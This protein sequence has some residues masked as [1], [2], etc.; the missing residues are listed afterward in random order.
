MGWR[1]VIA[2]VAMA[3]MFLTMC[4]APMAS[5]Q[6]H[7]ELSASPTAGIVVNSSRTGDQVTPSVFSIGDDKV[8]VVWTEQG[9]GLSRIFFS[10]ST[11]DGKTFSERKRVDDIG[12]TVKCLANDP[13][14][15]ANDNGTTVYVAWSDNRT[16]TYQIYMSVYGG[17]LSFSANQAVASTSQWWNQTNPDLDIEN[18][19][20]FLV[21][22]ED[23][24]GNNNTFVKFARFNNQVEP[25]GSPQLMPDTPGKDV[26]Q[27]PSISV[28]D[29]NISIAWHDARTN[30][31]FD[32]YVATS[33]DNGRDFGNAAKVSGP[34]KVEHW[35]PTVVNLPNGKIFLAWQ[36]RVSSSFDIVGAISTTDDTTFSSTF[37]ID[38]SIND[39]SVPKASADPR[40]V[41]SLVYRSDLSAGHRVMY[42]KANNAITFIPATIVDNVPAEQG[43]PDVYTISNGAIYMVFQDDRGPSVDGDDII[44]SKIV[45]DRPTVSIDYPEDGSTRSSLFSVQGSCLDPDTTPE[46][47]VQV[48]ITD[49][50]GE[51]VMD[52]TQ[53]NVVVQTIWNITINSTD[54]FDGDYEI[55]ARS[56]DGLLYSTEKSINVTLINNN[57]QP[58]VDLRIGPADI[59]YS[60]IDPVAQEN[61]TIYADIHND[62]NSD[63]TNVSVEFY[64]GGSKVGFTLLRVPGYSYNTTLI[65][66]WYPVLPL[67]Y[68]ITVKV[69]PD[70]YISEVNEDNNIASTQVVV[71]EPVVRKDLAITSQNITYS[72]AP[73]HVN[74][75]I[76]LSAKVSNIGEFLYTDVQVIFEIDGSQQ[77]IRHTG[78]IPPGVFYEV[79]ANWTPTSTGLHTIT[80]YVNSEVDDDT[81]NNQATKQIT[82]YEE[83]AFKAD[84][85]I[86]NA[87]IVL[88]PGLPKVGENVTIGVLVQNLGDIAA[89]HVTVS[90]Y[91]DG[92]LKSINVISYIDPGMA[93][94]TSIVWQAT[95]GPRTLTVKLDEANTVVETNESNN[96]VVKLFTVYPAQTIKPDLYVDDSN[97]SYSPDPPQKGLVLKI[98]VTV[99]NL[100][101]DSASNIEVQMKV[102]GSQLDG[103]MTI[104]YLAP[105]HSAIVSWNWMSSAGEHTF[106]VIVD[107]SNLTEEWSEANNTAQFSVELPADPISSDV[108][109]PILAVAAFAV[110]GFGIYSYW[111]SRQRKKGKA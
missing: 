30:P 90:F 67:T 43:S 14:V 99:W 33:H 92:L 107:P 108:W 53:A 111:K 36:E 2:A 29:S 55:H 64:V 85:A 32:I 63:A 4:L 65:S 50:L 100:G 7:A 106:E 91:I 21:F 83:T 71:S 17:G 77:I 52:W 66:N 104:G 28:R 73:A 41:V 72:P 37:S 15:V 57:P 89:T 48:K 39:Q 20:L 11:D 102:D 86:S 79:F 51:T 98:N 49:D 1:G 9:S 13:V 34:A 24:P 93:N 62:G 59:S 61:V 18:D 35:Y 80:V 74:E 88:S 105:G 40:G 19:V 97:I 76:N 16:G 78:S 46:L 8:Y 47:Q 58:T 110:L 81:S 95:L 87:S 27:F 38:G 42:T 23:R 75:L 25:I 54:F 96:Q 3:V 22:A 60:P 45:N 5:S 70:N 26:Q 68:T 31:L 84:L 56:F 12:P 94:D 44:F 101:N 109:L 6:A 10:M 82:V 69:D 103:I